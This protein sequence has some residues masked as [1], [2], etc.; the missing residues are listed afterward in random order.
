M[1]ST[2]SGNVRAEGYRDPS[3]FHKLGPTMPEGRVGVKRRH[4]GVD[5]ARAQLEIR[6]AHHEEAGRPSF[7]CR[8]PPVGGPAVPEVGAG[9]Q[10]P[11]AP[12]SDDLGGAIR[13]TVVDD[14]H[15][16][17]PVGPQRVQAGTHQSGGVVVDDDGD[18]RG[19]RS[20]AAARRSRR[21]HRPT[22]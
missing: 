13:R 18:H 11:T 6:I 10:P 2:M 8:R 20:S 4:Q 3:S 19:R 1:A 9:R 7:G 15:G 14:D 16:V 5:G 12:P 17:H 22:R 21:S